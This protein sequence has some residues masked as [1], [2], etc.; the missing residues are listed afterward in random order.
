[1]HRAPRRRSP[2]V[3]GSALAVGLFV[4]AAIDI[5]ACDGESVRLPD[6]VTHVSGKRLRARVLDAGGGAIKHVG[7]MDTERGEACVIAL[8]D[9]G[10]RR[11]L[12]I[13]HDGLGETYSDPECT[14]HVLVQSSATPPPAELAFEQ[15]GCDGFQLH[16]YFRVD[17]VSSATTS[18]LRMLDGACIESPVSTSQTIYDLESIP[19]ALVSFTTSVEERSGRL[20]VEVYAGSDGSIALGRTY[21]RERDAPCTPTGN[22]DPRCLPLDAVGAPVQYSA[23]PDCSVLGGGFTCSP[24]TCPPP[25]VVLERDYGA[26]GSTFTLH[27]AEPFTQAFSTD[28]DGKCVAVNF[29]LC[30]YAPSGKAIPKTDF[31]GFGDARVGT[32]RIVLAVRTGADDARTVE[33]LDLIDTTTGRACR[34][35]TFV[36]GIDRCV[37][38]G[39]PSVNGGGR[40]YAYPNCTTPFVSSTSPGCDAST[41]PYAVEWDQPDG[42]IVGDAPV[43]ALYAIAAPFAGIVYRRD[44]AT[45]VAAIESSGWITGAPIDASTL[46]PITTRTE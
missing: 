36:D 6:G 23:L 18:Y 12:P 7:W 5:V 24:S 29:G 8:F 1:M 25:T 39:A 10:V 30:R 15:P 28:P 26:C 17:G 19:D 22:D 43:K 9:D 45:C 20:G 16:G 14:V 13:D 38:A 41:P 42:V 37:D 46:A 32:G 27:D 40:L 33:E 31:P 21:D 4:F 44:G 35:Q 11:C 2:S 34:P 3:P